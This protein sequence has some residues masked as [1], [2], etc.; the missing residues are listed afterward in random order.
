MG[1]RR[2]RRW[3]AVV[4]GGLRSAPAQ[5]L[6]E[7]CR[8]LRRAFPCLIFLLLCSAG[9]PAIP[10]PPRR[11]IEDSGPSGST[12]PGVNPTGRN[13]SEKTLRL[14][15]PLPWLM[16]E[17]ALGA[18]AKSK[19]TQTAADPRLTELHRKIARQLKP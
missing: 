5:T 8:P 7:G 11:A 2:A 10:S 14:S 4:E 9:S 1:E 13:L 12:S 3:R 6:M 19:N 17:R 16:G 18:S 15:W